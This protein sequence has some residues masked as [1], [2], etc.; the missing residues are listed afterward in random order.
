MQNKRVID[1]LKMDGLNLNKNMS[2]VTTGVKEN[3][4]AKALTIEEKKEQALT[5]NANERPTRERVRNVFN[6]TQ[7]KLTVNNEIP[8]YKLHIFNDEPGRIQTAIDGGWEFVSPE[9]VGGVKDSVTS[10]NTDL[11]DKVRYLV[12]ASEKGDG[13]YAYLLKIKQEWWEEDQKEL[14]KRNDRVDDAIRG[15]VNV[16][17]GT[18]SEGFYTPRGG[19]NYKT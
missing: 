17:E 8:G 1:S 10:G 4:M 11:G 2:T 5:R 13:L 12:G 18:S 14:N 6:G 7:A 9:E 16:K 19:I 3:I 15:G